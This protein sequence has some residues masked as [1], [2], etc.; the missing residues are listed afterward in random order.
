[1]RIRSVLGILLLLGSASLSPVAG[2]DLADIRSVWHPQSETTAQALESLIASR[3]LEAAV[4]E[5]R[6]TIA[7]NEKYVADEKAMITLGYQYLRNGR[8]AEAVASF[9]INAEAHP[10][11][12]NAWDSLAE[13]HLIAGAPDKAETFY[14]KS[15]ELNPKNENG[16]ARLSEIRGW[17]LDAATETLRGAPFFARSKHG[18]ARPVLRTKTAGIKTR[19]FRSRNRVVGPKL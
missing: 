5:F 10:E 17:K 11:S 15:I 12:W 2:M 1:M 6:K 9:E 7:G 16:K 3:G 14:A 18:S 19:A 13:G 4:A 8:P